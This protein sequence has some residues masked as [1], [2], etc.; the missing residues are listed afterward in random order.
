VEIQEIR[1]FLALCE[2]LNCTRASERCTVSQPALT[3]AIQH[4]EGKLGGPLVHR[5]RKTHLTE[6]GR[7]MQAVVER[8]QEARQRARDLV[9][10]EQSRLTVGLMC[11]VGPQRLIDLFATFLQRHPGLE[12]GVKDAPAQYHLGP[13]V[14][15]LAIQSAYVA[16]KHGLAG[17]TKTVALE[18]AEDGITV[19]AICPGYVLTPLLEKQIPETARARGINEEN[20]IREVLLKA[21]PTRQFVGTARALASQ[22]RRR[23]RD[24]Q[25]RRDHH[26][27]RAGRPLARAPLGRRG[28][29][30]CHPRAASLRWHLYQYGLHTDQD[31]GGQRLCRPS[32]PARR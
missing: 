1:Y 8:M 19:N 7:S 23:S 27:H 9:K 3:R 4:L 32:R 26:R 24:A 2:T 18:T 11:T 21:Q 16:A 5:E 20:V 28:S 12:L 30:R 22:A 25:L 14:G 10:L 31:S 29:A 17:F 6:L 13:W 15:G